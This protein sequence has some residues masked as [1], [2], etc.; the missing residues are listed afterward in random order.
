MTNHAEIRAW[1]E[2]Q[3]ASAP[4]ICDEQR[5][6]AVRILARPIVLRP[7]APLTAERRGVA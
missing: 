1:V 3:L 2:K 5:E 6:V 4:P 7:A